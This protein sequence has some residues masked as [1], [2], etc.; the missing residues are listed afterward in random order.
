M[1]LWRKVEERNDGNK[2]P[3]LSDL[4]ESGAIEQDADIV[5][6]IHRP[7]YYTRSG[8]DA[9]G[10]NIK[11]M[12]EFIIAKH[13]S[14]SV[15]DVEMTF[16]GRFARFQNRTEGDYRTI[17]SQINGSEVPPTSDNGLDQIDTSAFPMNDNAFPGP[18][19]DFLKED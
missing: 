13:R 11:G 9:E 12:A 15:D 3:Q 8:T 17:D 1:P 14:G 16:V 4:R 6:F 7:E 10:R 2:R 18:N 19:P 5:C